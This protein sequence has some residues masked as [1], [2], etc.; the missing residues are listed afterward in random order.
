VFVAEVDAAGGVVVGISSVWVGSVVVVALSVVTGGVVVCSVVVAGGTVV[1]DSTVTVIV[2]VS[3]LI[4]ELGNTCVGCRGTTSVVV[5]ITDLSC[6]PGDLSLSLCVGSGS[7]TMGLS[8]E[9]V[10]S[11]VKGAPIKGRSCSLLISTTLAI[12]SP[13]RTTVIAVN[14]PAETKLTDV[15]FSCTFSLTLESKRGLVSEYSD[16]TGISALGISVLYCINPNK[17]R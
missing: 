15:A 14:A 7:V 5:G 10:G 12:A 11:E 4:T 3:I 16:G 1:V 2:V 13:L 8:E 9:V 17:T 6:S